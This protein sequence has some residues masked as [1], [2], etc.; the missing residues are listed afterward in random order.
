M[1]KFSELESFL[2][3]K[4]RGFELKPLGTRLLET[5]L[6]EEIESEVAAVRMNDWFLVNECIID[7][8]ILCLWVD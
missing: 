1:E 5:E 4:T 3:E 2:K 7:P 6:I 8:L